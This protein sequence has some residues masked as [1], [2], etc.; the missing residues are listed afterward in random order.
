MGPQQSKFKFLA[1]NKHR[2]IRYSPWI[3]L[4]R[5]GGNHSIERVVH[6]EVEPLGHASTE[7]DAT[8]TV[9]KRV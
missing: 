1:N 6:V 9:T 4:P 7:L 5:V 8:H 3:F 2:L